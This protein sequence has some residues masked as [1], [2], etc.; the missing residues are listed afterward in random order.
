MNDTDE[1]FRSTGQTCPSSETLPVSLLPT[2]QAS[3]AIAG[4]RSRSGDRK[5][6]PLLNGIATLSAADSLA[7]RY[8][9]PA[10]V[11]LNVIR[12]GSGR[13]SLEPFAYYDHDGFSSRTCQDYSAPCDPEDAYAAGLLD[14]EGCLRITKRE[15]WHSV[16]IEMSMAKKGLPLLNWMKN[17]YGGKVS[18]QRKATEKWAEAWRWRLFGKNA[19]EALKKLKPLLRLK[20]PQAELMLK[21][22]TVDSSSA[23]AAKLKKQVDELNAKGPV[24]AEPCWMTGQGN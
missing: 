10:G 12:A 16:W 3:Q 7:S 19:M 8:L 14:G 23:A 6:E 20:Q 13:I 22:A 9:L 11:R 21:L 2:P 1:F 5:N 17:R 24:P 18:L 15:R 4:A